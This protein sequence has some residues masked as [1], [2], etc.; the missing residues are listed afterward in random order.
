[1][2]CNYFGSQVSK[3][4]SNFCSSQGIAL[5]FIPER[6]PHFGE[7]F[8]A[9]VK[10]MKKHLSLVVGNARLIK[11]IPGNDGLVRV[12]SGTR[13]ESKLLVFFGFSV[14]SHVYLLNYRSELAEIRRQDT[15][16]IHDHNHTKKIFQCKCGPQKWA[17]MVG[18]FWGHNSKLCLE[19]I[20]HIFFTHG[21]QFITHLRFNCATFSSAVVQGQSS[22]MSTKAG[23]FTI[24]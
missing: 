6:A 1:M 14:C 10:S 24:F 23:F 21:L 15:D 4:P 16:T 8:E 2:Q 19:Q 7:L 22:Q 5:D 18:W 3:K 13:L 11:T 9:A 20:W 12:Y 17:V